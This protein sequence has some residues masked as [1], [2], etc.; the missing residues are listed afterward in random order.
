MNP[1]SKS[2]PTPNAHETVLL[3]HRGVKGQPLN[4]ARYAKLGKLFYWCMMFCLAVFWVWQGLSFDW[5]NLS[6]LEFLSDF[7]M[8]IFPVFLFFVIWLSIRHYLRRK[9]IDIEPKDSAS[10]IPIWLSTT[11]LAFEPA[12]HIQTNILNLQDIKSIKTDFSEGSRAL[13]IGALSKSFTL[14]SS[15]TQNLLHHLYSLRPDLE[16]SP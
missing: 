2:P 4:T 7:G 10:G 8:A 1:K 3:E 5:S 16:P 13:V 6:D 15:D 14:I 12:Q 9:N 11:R